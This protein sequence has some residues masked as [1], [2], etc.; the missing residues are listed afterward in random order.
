MG[1]EQPGTIPVGSESLTFLSHGTFAV[2]FGGHPLTLEV[3]GYGPNNSL[4][5]GA[6]ISAYAG[7]YGEIL[8]QT[9]NFSS[10]GLNVLDDITF[11][12]QPIP[13][14][15]VISM[16]GLGTL[17]FGLRRSRSAVQA[18]APPPSSS[19]SEGQ[20]CCNRMSGSGPCDYWMWFYQQAFRSSNY[21]NTPVAAITHTDEP[22]SSMN[23]PQIYFGLWAAG[24]NA[25]ICA[26]ATRMTPF[27]QEVGDPFVTR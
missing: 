11:S 4:L 16:L 1:I 5:Y 8:F 21:E 19:E 17:I 9:G 26:W 18:Q 13:E 24:K 12:P 23:E 15:G 14:P 10:V 25:A 3:L 22:H 7:T 6:D 20:R 27:F 2:S